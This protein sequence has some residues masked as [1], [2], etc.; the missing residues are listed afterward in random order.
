[1]IIDCDC[2]DNGNYCQHDQNEYH[3]SFP[4]CAFLTSQPFWPGG[5]LWRIQP[6]DGLFDLITKFLRGG[7]WPHAHISLSHKFGV[8]N[9]SDDLQARIIHEH[10]LVCVHDNMIQICDG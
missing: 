10:G 5:L 2:N 8:A 6:D 9:I 7:F 1:M 4:L 3:N